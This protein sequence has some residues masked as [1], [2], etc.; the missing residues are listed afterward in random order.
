MPGAL[1]TRSAAEATGLER[2]QQA[3]ERYAEAS[4][5]PSS[6]GTYRRHIRYFL[7]FLVEQ[8]LVDHVLDG[9]P[10]IMGLY[11]AWLAPTR[12]YSTVCTYLKGVRA[13]YLRTGRPDPFVAPAVCRV[14]EGV[15]RI[16]GGGPTQRKAPILP[17]MLEEWAGPGFLDIAAS[18]AG[19]ATFTAMVFAFFGFFRKSTVAVAGGAGSSDAAAA[20]ADPPDLFQRRVLRRC[21]IRIDLVN[22]C[23]WVTLRWTKT[24]QG[25][26]R[27]LVVPLAGR[28]GSILDPVALY[29]RLL[30]R[31]PSSPDTHAF[32]VP[33]AGGG[34]RPLSHRVF[35]AAIKRLAALSGLDPAEYAGHS[36][37]R[38]GASCAFAAGVCGELVQAHGDWR[39]DAYLAYLELSDAQRLEVSRAMQRALSSAP[40]PRAPPACQCP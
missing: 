12:T 23:V 21:D 1:V 38:G 20:L 16:N 19:L 40:R 37:R 9:H 2:L 39:S 15:R 18:D 7:R 22:Y 26:E 3:A 29:S 11:V 17:W 6:R 32:A 10:L 35:V 14:L 27:A 36:F 34:L 4:L 24:I 28:A 31:L 5:A 13:L 25:L 8:R 33:A 30:A